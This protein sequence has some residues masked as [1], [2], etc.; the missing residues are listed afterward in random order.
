MSSLLTAENISHVFSDG[1]TGLRDICFQIDKQDFLLLAGPNGSGKTL[2][3]EHLIGLKSPTKG[4]VSYKGKKIHK[5][6]KR[7]RNEV[8]LVFQNPDHQ[9]IAPTVIDDLRLSLHQRGLTKAEIDEKAESMLKKAGL[10]DLAKRKP[11]TLSGGEKKRLTIAAALMGDPEILILDEPFTGLDYKAVQDVLKLLLQIHQDQK[12][13]MVVSHD[14]EKI[15]AHCNRM[16]ILNNGKIV[17]DDH[18]EKLLDQLPE[19]RIRKPR[20]PFNQ[21]TWLN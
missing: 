14:I 6:L 5:N 21:M 13:I 16:V 19:N 20:I 12:T 9:I 1:D 4:T 18:P 15:A 17:N 3:L 10:T 8:A 2:L 7:L 11:H